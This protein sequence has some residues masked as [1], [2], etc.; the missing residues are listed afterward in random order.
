[1][2][3][4]LVPF[5]AI[6][7]LSFLEFRGPVLQRHFSLANFAALFAAAAAA[8]QYAAVRHPCR[9]R[10]DPDRRADRLGPGA[11]ALGLAT[12]LDV[13]ATMPFAVAGTVLAIG[14]VVSFNSGLADPDRRIADHGARLYGPQGAV[15]GAL[16]QRHRP[17]DRSV[18][19]GG[20]DQ[21]R[22]LARSY[23]SFG[24]SCR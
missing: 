22:R 24:S 13:V 18:A 8:D 12:V 15:R 23:R 3:L 6:V 21:P 4:A 1:M 17:P 2:L 11:H 16:F 14:F 20:L 9:L 10:C 19:R 7:V 5:F